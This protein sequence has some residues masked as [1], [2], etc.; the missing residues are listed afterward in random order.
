VQRHGS[1][2]LLVQKIG[3]MV[4]TEF[5]AAKHTALGSIVCAR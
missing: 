5:G 4:G 3:H 1:D 2:A